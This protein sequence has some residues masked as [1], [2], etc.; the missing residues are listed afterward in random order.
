MRVNVKVHITYLPILIRVRV[1]N[2]V[3]E[4]GNTVLRESMVLKFYNIAIILHGIYIESLDIPF[5]LVYMPTAISY[6]DKS[7]K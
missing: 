3:I 6:L 4:G 5:L 2:C 7:Y 1:S